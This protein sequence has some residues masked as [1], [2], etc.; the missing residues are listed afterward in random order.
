MQLYRRARVEPGLDRASE[1]DRPQ[2]RGVGR[3]TA[4]AEELA[5]VTRQA[6]HVVT[7]GH[8]RDAVGEVVLPRIA[9]QEALTISI[10]FRNHERLGS[11]TRSAQ[12]P[13]DLVGGGDAAGT[14]QP[15]GQPQLQDLHRILSRHEHA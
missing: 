11:V 1:P 7:G 9:C 10:E 3:A 5:A 13:L 12:H 4:P 6:V 2:A 14:M 15:V 8:E